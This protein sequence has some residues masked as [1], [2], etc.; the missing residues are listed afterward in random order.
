MEPLNDQELDTSFAQGFLEQWLKD[1]PPAVLDNLKTMV[2][3]VKFYRQKYLDIQSDYAILQDHYNRL[4][5]Q[6]ALYLQ[7]MQQQKEQMDQLLIDDQREF[8]KTE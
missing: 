5:A 7:H 2:D 1:E 3:G 4:T 8:H 6:S